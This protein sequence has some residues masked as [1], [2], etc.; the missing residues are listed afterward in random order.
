MRRLLTKE[1]I[2]T[3]YTF[4]KGEH[5]NKVDFQQSE[6]QR[7]EEEGKEE[8]KFKAARQLRHLIQLVCQVTNAEN[9]WCPRFND[10]P[11]G[12]SSLCVEF[13]FFFFFSQYQ[14]IQ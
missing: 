1:N 10:Q 13:K 6:L 5:F 14:K 8:G 7:K 12:G 11:G 4:N 3:K 2:L 9:K